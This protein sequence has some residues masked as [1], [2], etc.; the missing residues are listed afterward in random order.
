MNSAFNTHVQNT[1]NNH[2]SSDG[3]AHTAHQDLYLNHNLY[4]DHMALQY[5]NGLWTH[6][7]SAFAHDYQIWQTSTLFGN[8][9]LH[10]GDKMV[11]HQ[12]RIKLLKATNLSAIFW[13]NQVHGNVSS[14]A[15]IIAPSAD[16][17]IMDSANT[18]KADGAMPAR[19]ALAIMTADCVPIALLGHKNG[20]KCMAVIHA[21]WRGLAN[22]VIDNAVGAFDQAIAIIGV[23]ICQDC[24]QTDAKF[25]HDFTK[26]LRL[27]STPF[28]LPKGD[29]VHISLAHT[30]VHILVKYHIKA[31]HVQ[32][33][34][35]DDV[36]F[37]S[38][39]RAPD[40]GRHAL[41]VA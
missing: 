11:A 19:Q 16:A 14:V 20:H 23:H 2:M 17:L 28:C 13:A 29:K 32:S 40:I 25:A 3:N 5:D 31:M 34:S 22:G 30:A 6:K 9:A 27:P 33:C 1:H 7:I 35:H 8:I 41:I 12:N 39:R 15:Q 10:V 38:H 37:F 24:Y 4:L 21:G 26:T 18:P 36:R